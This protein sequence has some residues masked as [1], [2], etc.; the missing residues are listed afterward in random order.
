M[1]F[2]EQHWKEI[3]AVLVTLVG[4]GFVIKYVSNRNTTKTN[5]VTQRDNIVGGDIAGRDIKKGK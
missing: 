4:G 3:I 5:K 2:F 1:E